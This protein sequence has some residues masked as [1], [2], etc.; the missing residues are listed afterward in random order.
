MLKPRPLCALQLTTG[1]QFLE[2]KVLLQA[3][4]LRHYRDSKRAQGRVQATA[5]KRHF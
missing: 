4:Q 5:E 3:G 1:K 2:G